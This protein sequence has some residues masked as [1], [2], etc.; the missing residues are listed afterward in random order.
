MWI[1]CGIINYKLIIPLIYPL[2]Y[3]IRRIIHK[4]DEKPFLQFFTNYLGYLLSGLIYLFIKWRMK[5]KKVITKNNDLSDK[6]VDTIVYELN[7]LF[8]PTFNDSFDRSS[9][10]SFVKV[11]TLVN[12]KTVRSENSNQIAL[13][14]I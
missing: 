1:E 11:K 13:E 12:T 8:V 3:Q 4:N 2:F 5:K 10:S 9:T 7:D 14:K 6:D